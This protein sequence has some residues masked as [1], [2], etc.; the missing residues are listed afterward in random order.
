[1]EKITKEIEKTKEELKLRGYSPKTVKS[2]VYI[3]KKFLIEI[4]KSSLNITENGVRKYLLNL[5]DKNYERETIRLTIAGI[6]FYLRN[7]E[8]RNI[9][10]SS[11]PLPKRKKKLP[12]VLEKSEIK[13]MI[14]ITSNLKH[15]LIIMLAY[16]SGLRVSEL[17]NLKVQ[18]LDTI[19]NTLIVREGKGSKDRLTIF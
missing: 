5:M 16:S 11:I 17:T 3:I 13:A 15:K 12:K 8:K 10:L 9:D 19:N 4:Q 2:Y 6:K 7:V 18:D 1:M 14:E